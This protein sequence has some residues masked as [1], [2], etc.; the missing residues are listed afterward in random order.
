ML[1]DDFKMIGRLSIAVND[2]VVREIPN[3]VVTDGK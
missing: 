1:Q 2:E 3:L